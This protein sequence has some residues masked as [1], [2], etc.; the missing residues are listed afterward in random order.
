MGNATLFHITFSKKDLDCIPEDEAAFLLQ[1]GGLIHEVM[2]LQKFIHMSSHGTEDYI[3]RMA[4]NAQA[5]YFYRLLAGSL[6][7]GWEL[8]TVRHREYKAIITKY[9]AR[10]DST[11]KSSF[12]KLENYFSDRNNACE[13]IR[14]KFS[15]HHDYGEILKIIK[16]W[17]EDGKLEVYLS[18]T[19]ANCRYVASDIVTNLATLGTTD[20]RDIQPRLEGLLQE[21]GDIARAFIDAISEYLS[22]IL[23]EIT[24]K[25]EIKI[26][27]ISI[28]NIP[29]LDKIRL[30]YFV[31][32]PNS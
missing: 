6:F 24:E 5:M 17:P 21:I 19:H 23:Q 12:E 14:N 1:L 7:E 9:R 16:K 8:L 25:K 13:R 3:Q 15:H 32:E 29:S 28:G 10:L 26:K 31:S 30:H 4:E 22:L 18:E 20:L 11:A 2:S 27:E